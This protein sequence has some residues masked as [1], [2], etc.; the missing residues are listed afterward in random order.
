MENYE[1]KMKQ[2]QENLQRK[3][4]TIQEVREMF[5]TVAFPDV[6]EQMIA[7]YSRGT[8]LKNAT[9]MTGKSILIGTFPDDEQK[10]PHEFGIIS[11]QYNV[12]THE[13]AIKTT[14]DTLKDFPEFGEPDFNIK[15]LSSG[16]RMRYTIDFPEVKSVPITVGD[17]VGIRLAGKNG[18]DLL[19]EYVVSTEAAALVCLNGLIGYEMLEKYSCRHKS[20]L[21]LDYSGTV[22]AGSMTAFSEQTEVWKRWASKQLG[23][24]EFKE[25]IEGLPF[26]SRHTDQILELPI[27]Q[28]DTTLKA[29]GQ[30]GKAT[31]WDTN[32]AV[33]Q[34]LTHEVE[35]EIVTIEKGEKV[36][37]YL[38]K[39]GQLAITA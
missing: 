1:E 33:T 21:N 6:E 31:L 16:A 3:Q 35:S 4:E 18:Y 30:K 11:P 19:W 39:F 26:G 36:A 29:L 10:I 13:E 27:I 34:F 15:V 32:L 14:L 8:D 37:K 17:P 28:K 5:P 22:I 25:I 12:V 9:L 20:T 23:T 7:H 24:T 38:H 2:M